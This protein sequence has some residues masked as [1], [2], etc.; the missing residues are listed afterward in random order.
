ME[1]VMR[2]FEKFSQI[3]RAEKEK[4]NDHAAE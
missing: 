1:E 4:G 2:F 3:I